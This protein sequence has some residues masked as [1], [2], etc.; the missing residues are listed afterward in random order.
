MD[1]QIQTRGNHL[2][3]FNNYKETEILDKSKYN[4]M[5]T[6]SPYNSSC[7]IP[8]HAIEN[9]E[10]AFDHI[11]TAVQL[12]CRS[13]IERA[14]KDAVCQVRVIIGDNSLCWFVTI[15]I[16]A[17]GC[18]SQLRLVCFVHKLRSRDTNNLLRKYKQL[19]EKSQNG[20][21]KLPFTDPRFFPAR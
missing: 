3:N 11:G 20:R 15:Q 16:Y 21:D 9:F 12:A 5:Y 19:V 14:T 8:H 2:L 17:F 1:E 7:R 18:T 13:N 10:T 6:L 4:Y